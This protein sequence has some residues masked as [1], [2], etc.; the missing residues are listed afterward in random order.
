ME[1]QVENHSSNRNIW[2]ILLKIVFNKIIQNLW[3][4]LCVISAINVLFNHFNK[5][6]LN[7]ILT[8]SFFAGLVFMNLFQQK[9]T[10]F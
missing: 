8:V 4:F 7:I 3:L 5:L 1:N 9:K 2:K 10:Y 6:L